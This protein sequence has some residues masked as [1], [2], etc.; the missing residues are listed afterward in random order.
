METDSLREVLLFIVA[1]L[2][3]ECGHIFAALVLG[4]PV[5]SFNVRSFGG[6]LPLIS[7]VWDTL[8]RG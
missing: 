2:V 3:H 5:V 6:S 1:L 4:V 7:R 8:K